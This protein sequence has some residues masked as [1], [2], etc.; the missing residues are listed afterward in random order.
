MLRL[1]ST[2]NLFFLAVTLVAVSACG[3]SGG[4]DDTPPLTPQEEAALDIAGAS[5]TRWTATSISF[6]GAP[7]NGFDN[8][9]LTLRGTDPNGSLT[10]SSVSGDPIFNSSGSWSFNGTSTTQF[11]IDGN[12]TN[13]FTISGLTANEN[14]TLTVNFT[15]GGGVAAGTTGTDGT[16]VFTLVAQ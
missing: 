4:G 16:Y 14:M 7:A 13:V 8:F 12:S 3:G 15:S 10:Y 9:S 11:I 1:R 5:G 2:L 6:D